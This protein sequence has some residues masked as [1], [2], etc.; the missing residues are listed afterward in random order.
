MGTSTAAAIG[1][2]G[3]YARIASMSL[4]ENPAGTADVG[5]GAARES[6]SRSSM[7]RRRAIRSFNQPPPP[8][9]LPPAL[10]SS[11]GSRYFVSSSSDSCVCSAATSLTGRPVAYASFAIFAPAS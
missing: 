9:D 6:F 8:W 3:K 2:A 7:S 4:A 10:V 1:A 11:R 5:S